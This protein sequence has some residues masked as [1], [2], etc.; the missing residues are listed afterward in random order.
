M[1]FD[2]NSDMISYELK[3]MPFSEKLSN[4]QHDHQPH[5]LT[6]AC[7]CP[8]PPHP[9]DPRTP[10]DHHHQYQHHHHCYPPVS[11]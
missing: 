10:G 3:H 1:G 6:C 5:K 4:K 7:L 2:P 9:G 11:V 8:L